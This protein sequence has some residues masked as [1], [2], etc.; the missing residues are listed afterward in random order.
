M[1][2][3]QARLFPVPADRPVGDTERFGIARFTSD[4]QLDHTFQADGKLL[5]D[6][7]GAF[8]AATDVLIQPDGKIIA[9]G[10]ARNVSGGGLGIVRVVP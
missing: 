3:Q 9:A 8:D 4:G 1:C 6:F 7:F 10:S 5:V 2:E